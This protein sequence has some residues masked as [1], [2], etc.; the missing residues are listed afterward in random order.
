MTGLHPS[1]ITRI[2]AALIDDGLLQ[3]SGEGHTELGRKPIVLRLVDDAVHVIALAVEAGSVSGVL[4]NLGAQIL[5]RI[6]VPF[7]PGTDHDTIREQV[8]LVTDG[9]LEYARERDI[10]VAGIGVAMH[11]IVD[12]SR[13]ISVFAPAIG[14][15]NVPLASMIEEHCGLPVLMENNAK[16]MVLGEYWFGNGQGVRD[17]L[18]VK[19]GQSIGSGIILNG[20]LLVGA[21]HSSGEIGH[22]TVVS[23]GAR[24]KCGNYGCL[25]TVAST[26][27]VLKK[28]RVILKRENGTGLLGQQAI[29]PDELTY[30]DLF[31]AVLAD[32][33]LAR[34][35]WEEAAAFLGVALANTINILNPAKV[36][37]GGDILPIVAYLLPRIREIVVSRVFD[38]VKPSLEIEPVGLGVNAVLVGAATLVLKELLG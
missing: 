19:V 17:L 5:K 20:D 31:E 27:A 26:E 23:D 38:T 11:G 6:D 4:I 24:C 1:T 30:D 33:Q 12:S 13:G 16:A 14:W 10:S 8:F 2:V 34:Q 28:W 3:E 36:L 9:L 25:E 35:L 22:T 37:I 32:D 18:A 7:A 15:R 21:D 29:D